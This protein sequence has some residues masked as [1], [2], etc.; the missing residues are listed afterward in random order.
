MTNLAVVRSMSGRRKTNWRLLQQL[1]YDMI[2]TETRPVAVENKCRDP[3][4]ILELQ[5]KRKL[6]H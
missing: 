2:A 6:A 3:E 4:H 1:R 5:L